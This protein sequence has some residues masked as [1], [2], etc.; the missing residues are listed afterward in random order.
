M[1]TSA[2]GAEPAPALPS[3]PVPASPPAG[4]AATAPAAPFSG[5]TIC[6]PSTTG[7]ARFTAASSAL[8]VGPPA[9]SSASVTRAPAGRRTTPGER[10]APHTY[11]TTSGVGEAAGA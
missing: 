8:T 1:L 10:T 11:T 3:P 6:W 5:T 9:I 2:A 4:A 7:A